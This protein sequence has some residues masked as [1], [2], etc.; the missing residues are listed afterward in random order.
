MT[1]QL[2]GSL[3]SIVICS[4]QISS[5]VVWLCNFSQLNI[6]VV[7]SLISFFAIKTWAV[8]LTVHPA[9]GQQDAEP[10]FSELM[11]EFTLEFFTFASDAKTA[12][13]RVNEL[14]STRLSKHW[15]AF[16]TCSSLLLWPRTKL[17]NRTDT[18]SKNRR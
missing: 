2:S 1:L 3:L 4:D 18:I 12:S 11:V 5:A 10:L 15:Y 6:S 16:F 9:F 8:S 17:R 13:S 7:F 14:C